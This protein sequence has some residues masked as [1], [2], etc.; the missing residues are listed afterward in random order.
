MAAFLAFTGVVIPD[1]TDSY[2]VSRGHMHAYLH[3][4]TDLTKPVLSNPTAINVNERDL[5]AL[6]DTDEVA[7]TCYC[8]ASLSATKPTP[9]QVSQSK[10]HNGDTI[11]GGSVAVVATGTQ[12]IPVDLLFGGLTYYLHFTHVD[13]SSNYADV[14][15]SA[16]I[17]MDPAVTHVYDVNTNEV[18]V[19]GEAITITGLTYEASQQTGKAEVI[20]GSYADELSILT[21]A[22]QE[23]TGAVTQALTTACPFTDANHA[24]SVKV[25]SHSSGNESLLVTYNPPSGQTAYPLSAANTCLIEAQSVLALAG[26]QDGDQAILPASYAGGDITWETIGGDATGRFTVSNG[27]GN[28]SFEFRFWDAT[29]GSVIVCEVTTSQG[30]IAVAGF[31]LSRG[32]MGGVCRLMNI[33]SI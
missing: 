20:S 5:D 21:W 1:G 22:D 15:T 6:V 2:V 26:V 9:L 4:G 31:L 10:N 25:T 33:G 24:V 30:A 17:L 13:E 19:E 27:D 12:T 7:G 3:D 28:G 14:V 11:Q 16:G 8:V 23:I 29:D 32:L 18:V